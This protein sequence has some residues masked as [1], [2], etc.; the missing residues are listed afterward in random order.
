MSLGY[1]SFSSTGVTTYACSGLYLLADPGVGTP[2][3]HSPCQ[4]VQMTVYDDMGRLTC[5]LWQVCL[6]VLLHIAFLR[7]Y[8]E[9]LLCD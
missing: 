4:A 6:L 5:I 3:P 8:L 1:G 2:R 7:L 9:M